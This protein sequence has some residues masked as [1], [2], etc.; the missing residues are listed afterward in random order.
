MT[1]YTWRYVIVIYKTGDMLVFGNLPAPGV[2][3]VRATL[4][5]PSPATVNALI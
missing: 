4:A 5:A 2:T 3:I 1:H